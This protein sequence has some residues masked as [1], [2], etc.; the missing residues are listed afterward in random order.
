MI[1][2]LT[3]HSG[4]NIERDVGNGYVPD[5]R[6]RHDICGTFEFELETLG[7]SDSRE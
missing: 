6:P 1:E 2:E 4:R 3:F 7:I 5:C